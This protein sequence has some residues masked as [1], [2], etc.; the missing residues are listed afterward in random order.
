MTR[1]SEQ[2][3]VGAL[4]VAGLLAFWP[5]IIALGWAVACHNDYTMTGVS[6]TF[7]LFTKDGQAVRGEGK[8]DAEALD[9]VRVQIRSPVKLARAVLAAMPAEDRA[10][11][12]KAFCRH[13]GAYDP[14][15]RC[16]DDD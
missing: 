6:H 15:C 4:V 9:Q 5:L 7:W 3:W 11:T 10:E 1:E 13:C 14:V 2:A 12:F 8:T 16:L